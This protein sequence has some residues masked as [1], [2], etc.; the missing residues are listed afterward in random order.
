MRP[1]ARYRYVPGTPLLEGYHVESFANRALVRGGILSVALPYTI[2]MFVAFGEHV[3]G[4]AAWLLLPVAGPWVTLATRRTQCGQIGEPSPGG[5]DCFADQ[6]G[7]ALLVAN[8]TFQTLGLLMIGFG[9]FD[10]Q[11]Y[12]VW[13][14]ATNSITPAPML[15]GYG[16][17]FRRDL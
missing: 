16:L 10:R 13:Q 7:A 2:G 8:G 17:T 9:I 14:G 6:Y 3:E 15:S 1:P 5:A 4:S 11:E 12:A